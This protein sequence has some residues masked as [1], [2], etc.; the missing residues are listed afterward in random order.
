MGKRTPQELEEE[1][2][3][4]AEAHP[5]ANKLVQAAVKNMPRVRVE[6]L[7]M[8][9]LIK[10]FNM[11]SEVEIEQEVFEKCPLNS[12]KLKL[13]A[14]GI[15]SK[16]QEAF[17]TERRTSNTVMNWG[18][19]RLERNGSCVDQVEKLKREVAGC[20]DEAQKEQ[21][22]AQNGSYFISV[23]AHDSIRKKK[24]TELVCRIEDTFEM[25]FNKVH[26][27]VSKI[28]SA[29]Y[30]RFALI[31]DRIVCDLKKSVLNPDIR[32]GLRSP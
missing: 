27:V 5:N 19:E 15:E 24:L 4:Y 14:L 7:R 31:G 8:V 10:E 3:E 25:V 22:S 18:T 6:S 17:Y 32:G 26:C 29:A 9:N 16:E 1:I 23:I 11:K 12:F 30:T 20:K 28:D 21:N 13:R 2:K